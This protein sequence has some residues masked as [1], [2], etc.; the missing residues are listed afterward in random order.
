MDYREKNNWFIT[1]SKLKLFLQSPLLYKAVYI[2]NVD[3]SNLKEVSALT[4]GTIVDKFLLTPDEFEKEY[5]FPVE[6]WLKDDLIKACNQM[7]IELTGKEKVDDLKKLVY[8]DKKVLTEAQSNLVKGIMDE[9][10]RQ[11]LYDDDIFD[12]TKEKKYEKQ[13]E[14]VWEYCGAKL[15]WTLDRFAVE[16]DKKWNYTKVI[17]RDLKTTSD[18]YYNNYY[19]TTQFAVNLFKDDPYNYKLQMAMYVGLLKTNHPDIPLDKV[20][21]IIDAVGTTDPFFYQAIKLDVNELRD[22]WENQIPGLL[23]AIKNIET[24]SET[25]VQRDKLCQNRYYKLDTDDCIQK[26]YVDGSCISQERWVEPD[27]ESDD[28]DWDNL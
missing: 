16:A 25:D 14:L 7:K 12:V 26:E 22:I 27:I 28:F 21:V 4:T 23:E 15:K 11:P 2:D 3:L 24:L 19:H 5:T 18:M 13:Y 8:G 10:I 17:I 1:A 6:G 20:E 9:V